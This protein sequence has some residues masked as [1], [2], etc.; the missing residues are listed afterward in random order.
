[1]DE[2]K[3]KEIF[4]FHPVTGIQQKSQYEMIREAAYQ[5]AKIIVANT[6]PCADQTTAIRHIRD[7][8]MTANAAVA[9]E[10]LV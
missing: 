7:A 9:L 2:K 10:G 4:T 1:M 3:L 8:A 6:K 5:F